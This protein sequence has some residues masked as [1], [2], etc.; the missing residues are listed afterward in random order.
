[1]TQYGID[2]SVWQG[3]MDWSDV[4]AA[5]VSFS[6]A[7]ASL[8]LGRDA[9][10]ASHRD[11]ALNAQLVA[12]AYHYLTAESPTAQAD[13]FI[14]ATNGCHGILAALDCEAQGLTIGN[15][16][17]FAERFADRTG[18]HPLFIYTSPSFWKAHGNAA[19]TDLGPLW[20]AYYPGGG[21]PGDSSLVWKWSIGG[22]KPTI[23]QYGPRPIKDRAA[24]DGDAFRGT[25]AE[26]EAF[27]GGTTA[28][29][30]EAVTLPTIN[31]ETPRLVDLHVGDE[32]LD[33]SGKPLVSVSVA[34]TQES[35]WSVKLAG[36]TYYLVSVTT[37]GVNT[38][39]LLHATAAANARPVPVPIPNCD[40]AVAAAEAPLKATIVDREDRL[41]RSSV[42]TTL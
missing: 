5:G 28:G 11:G 35:P 39:A 19:L 16:R 7:R 9:T 29:P 21:Y 37:G 42:I 41:R 25:R 27:I 4:K 31:D 15:I 38:P 2:I 18:G 22:V 26:L 23:W 13:V 34:Q 17:L 32:L 6:V 36:G 3:A 24:V 12:G 10:F 33:L 8:G 20:L 14:S 30:E 1:M 40:A